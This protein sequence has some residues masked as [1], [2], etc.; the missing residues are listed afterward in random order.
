MRS[1]TQAS[2]SVLVFLSFMHSALAAA[3]QP[4]VVTCQKEDGY[5]AGPVVPTKVVARQIYIAIASARYPKSWRKFPSIFVLDG[6]S[7]WRVGQEGGSRS[8]SYTDAKGLVIET[9]RTVEGGGISKWK[10]TS[11]T[12]PSG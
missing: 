12:A 7:V 10:L 5:L 11:A 2:F 1:R 8:S 6:G 3:E 9:V 4:S